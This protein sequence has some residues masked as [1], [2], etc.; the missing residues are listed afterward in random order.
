M[1]NVNIIDYTIYFKLSFSFNLIF[2]HWTSQVMRPW[3][4]LYFS[5]WICF[6]L[7]FSIRCKNSFGIY[8]NYLSLYYKEGHHTVRNKGAVDSFIKTKTSFLAL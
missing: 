6:S 5:K 4:L 1:I 8:S 2:E 7:F 3:S